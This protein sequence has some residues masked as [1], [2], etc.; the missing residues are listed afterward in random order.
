[1][2]ATL[3]VPE[4]HCGHCKASIEGALSQ[5]EGVEGA[6]VD[7]DARTV[8]VD[9]DEDRVER[10]TIVATITSIGYDVVAP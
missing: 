3:N 9:Y 10:D 8:T 6:E 7:L 5:L 1:M 4:V 2:R